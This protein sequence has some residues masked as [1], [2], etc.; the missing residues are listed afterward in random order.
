MFQLFRLD[1]N[2]LGNDFMKI[3]VFMNFC[4]TK[5]GIHWTVLKIHTKLSYRQLLF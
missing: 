3:D 4:L 1:I 5:N 2:N